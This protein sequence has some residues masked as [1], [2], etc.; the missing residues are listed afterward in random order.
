MDI[1]KITSTEGMYF[2]DPKEH[3]IIDCNI[4]RQEL[5]NSLKTLMI[6]Y[7]GTIIGRTEDF[8]SNKVRL[9][10]WLKPNGEFIE[11]KYRIRL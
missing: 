3:C 4:F 8:Y 5:G 7:D 11:K 6:F 1:K 9:D 2:V 10:F